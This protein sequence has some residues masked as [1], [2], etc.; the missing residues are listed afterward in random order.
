MKNPCDI[1]IVKVTCT[2]IC[3]EKINYKALLSTAVEQN[4]VNPKRGYPAGTNFTKYIKM[5]RQNQAE[6]TE[7][8]YRKFDKESG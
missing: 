6:I 3:A 5:K 2:A 8:S 4:T 1:C 7:I